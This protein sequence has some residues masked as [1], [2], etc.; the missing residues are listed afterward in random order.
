[1]V[2]VH[3]LVSM[4]FSA[5]SIFRRARKI[6]EYEYPSSVQD[7][8]WRAEGAPSVGRANPEGFPVLYL[9]DRPET[10]FSEIHVNDETVLLSELRLREG[11]KCRIA[12]V[13][14]FQQIQRTGRGFLSGDASAVINNMLNACDLEQARSLLIAD[15]FLFKCLVEDDEKYTVSSF[16]AKSIFEKN[17]QISTVAYP[18]V[19]QYGAINFAVKTDGFWDSWSVVGARRMRVRH[20]ACGYYE[21]SQAEHVVVITENG[22][23][24]WEQ[25]VVADNVAQRLEPA[26][27]PDVKN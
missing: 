8:L 22:R 26:W 13:G 5:G 6:G 20:Q 7:L 19:R 23:L 21:T 2:K 4:D 9:A 11:T 14:E 18:S 10:A 1:M 15:A 3:P 16:V 12:P 17:R 25:G 24:D 27:Y